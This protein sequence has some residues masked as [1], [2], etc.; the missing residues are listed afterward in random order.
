[1]WSSDFFPG[2]PTVFHTCGHK[3][4]RGFVKNEWF[5]SNDKLDLSAQ[6][7]WMGWVTPNMQHHLVLAIVGVFKNMRIRIGHFLSPANFRIQIASGNKFI[8]HS[9]HRGILPAFYS[10]GGHFIFG[11][12][13]KIFFISRF[14]HFPWS[15]SLPNWRSDGWHRP[16]QL[17][18]VENMKNGVQCQKEKTVSIFFLTTRMKADSKK[19]DFRL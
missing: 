19:S 4:C 18:Q 10:A 12:G 6:V 5:P 13:H 17:L 8:A 3:E 11:L 16:P 7:F 14:R 1:M 15:S 9:C 2:D